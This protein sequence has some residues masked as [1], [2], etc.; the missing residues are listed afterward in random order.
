[1]G[2]RSEYAVQEDVDAFKLDALVNQYQNSTALYKHHWVVDR[3]RNSWLIPVKQL[4]NSESI[5]VFHY[6]DTNI[7]IKL[8]KITDGWNLTSIAPN[9]FN[10]QEVIHSLR[11]ALNVLG[12]GGAIYATQKEIPSKE[13]KETQAKSKKTA[14]RKI[15]Y[16]DILTAIVVGVIIFYIANDTKISSLMKS[17]DNKT[18]QKVQ[19]IQ[20]KYNIC[21]AEY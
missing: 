9:P 3:Q 14:K 17:D 16:L 13:N 8:Y 10:N 1:M 5:W 21:V 7:E 6:K 20:S 15:G 2:F 18:S 11:E 12:D 19:T 4:N